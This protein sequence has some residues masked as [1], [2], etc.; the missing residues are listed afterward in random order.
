MKSKMAQAKGLGASGEGVHDWMFIRITAL[1]NIPLVLWLVVSM[2]G[3]KGAPYLV[4]LAWVSS[5][6]NAVLL[7]LLVI[8][9]FYHAVLGSQEIIED[10]IH[11]KGFKMFKLIG[12]RLFFFALGVACIFSILKIAF[13]AGA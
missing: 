9:V 8:S 6:L 4:F 13:T 7:I 1:A 5:P 11:H 3:L 2:A 12:Q 10:Y